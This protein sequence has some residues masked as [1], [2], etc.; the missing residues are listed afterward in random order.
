MHVAL[1][2]NPSNLLI[3]GRT[4]TTN[5]FNSRR[6]FAGRSTSSHFANNM[7]EGEEEVRKV[8]GHSE[9]YAGYA[10]K[11]SEQA[12]HVRVPRRDP[13]AQSSEASAVPGL[14]PSSRV[15]KNPGGDSTFHLG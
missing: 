4:S 8:K 15:L 9:Q 2:L 10:M 6:A 11:V 1:S 7:I 3:D 12:M 14:R 5:L 13:N